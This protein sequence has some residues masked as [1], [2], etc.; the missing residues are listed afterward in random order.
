MSRDYVPSRSAAGLEDSGMN[1]RDIPYVSNGQRSLVDQPKL[2]SQY[3]LGKSVALT[4]IGIVGPPDRSR[5]G[6]DYRDTVL[7]E[8][9]RDAFGSGFRLAVV[10]CRSADLGFWR[11]WLIT[12]KKHSKRRHVDNGIQP[13]Q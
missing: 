4:Q 8:A 11:Q 5:V 3:V 7:L 13:K 9:P 1:R 12:R 2:P 6:C 10:R